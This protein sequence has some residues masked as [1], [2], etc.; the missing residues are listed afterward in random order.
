MAVLHPRSEYFMSG[1]WYYSH[2]GAT[3]GPFSVDDL[4]ARAAK[5]LLVAA[6]WIWR[7]GSD[8]ASGIA[9]LAALDFDHLP[10][11]TAP[12]PD[13]L[14]D[15]DQL[16]TT[17]PIPLPEACHDQPEW[18]NDLCIWYGLEAFILVGP[19]LP[20][21][22]PNEIGESFVPVPS[23]LVPD[24][25]AE[26]FPE[27][28]PV[29]PPGASPSVPPVTQTSPK[30]T[31]PTAQSAAPA[32]QPHISS[33]TARGKLAATPT[34]APTTPAVQTP[35]TASLPP[36]SAG[37]DAPIALPSL[38]T[39]VS[40]ISSPTAPEKS[41]VTPTVAPTSPVPLETVS[42][43]PPTKTTLRAAVAWTKL[44]PALVDLFAQRAIDET[45]FDPRS[46]EIVDRAQFQK[47][48]QQKTNPSAP[49]HSPTNASM[50]ELFRRGRT[51]IENW[52]DDDDNKTL[53]LHGDATAIEGN[54]QLA[55]I[56]ADFDKFGPAMRQKLQAHLAFM[57]ENRRKYYAA[58]NA[59]CVVGQELNRR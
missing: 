35:F 51:A 22:S 8:K 54:P 11:A 30:R 52:V 5:G 56:L 41:P 57:I 59:Q 17:G 46:G 33:L 4:K 43:A 45:G 48:K 1:N 2:D 31:M 42:V 50:M 36:V 9:A 12:M 10:K 24:W 13:W 20:P 40:E 21:T 3:H 37:P 44:K 58:Y 18:L 25:L 15:V 6:N 47:W 26:L 29:V 27:A 49:T 16:Q 38:P 14:A 55:A 7:E 23:A 32:S 39:A 28:K 53:V 19:G 34:V